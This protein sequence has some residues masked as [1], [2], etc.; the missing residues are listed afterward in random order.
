[1]KWQVFEDSGSVA[2]EACELILQAARVAISDRGLFKIVLAGGSTPQ[3][4]YRLLS[5]SD[6]QWKHWE[7]YFGDERCLPVEDPERN[8][9]MAARSLTDQVGIPFDQV[10][11]IPAELGPEEAARLYTQDVEQALP[12]DLV[13]LG[14]GED[15]HTASL[16]PG[17]E[18]P[19][20]QLVHSVHDAPK[21]PADRVSLSAIALGNT[22][23]LLFLITGSNKQDT[24]QHWHQG[25]KLPISTIQSPDETQVLIDKAAMG[26]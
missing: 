6:S 16:F 4:A 11:P 3:R 7:V 17:H 22:R 23:Q 14:M 15:G 18:H 19:Q 8:S 1:M 24:V 20:D 5:Q 21:P 10:H 13:L 9:L 26:C 25:K 2:H 12:F